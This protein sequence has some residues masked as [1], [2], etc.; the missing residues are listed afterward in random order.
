MSLDTEKIIVA[1]DHANFDECKSF[2][3]NI[4]SSLRFVKVGSILYSAV[5]PEILDFFSKKNVKVFLDLKYH[6]IPNTVANSI[7][8]VLK[9]AP[10]DLLT[11][12]ASG[13]REMIFEAKQAIRE[14]GQKTELVAVTILTSLDH[15]NLQ[16]IGFGFEPNEAVVNLARLAI[17]SGADGIVCSS[18]ELETVRRRIPKKM[19]I[20][21]PG[22]RPA[23]Q[24]KAGDDQKRTAT[25]EYAFDQGASYI[26]VGRPITQAKN[27]A[28]ILNKIVKGTR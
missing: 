17:D 16:E 25:P 22:I 14:S 21:V 6:D 9:H 24:E 4:G 27:P 8:S 10:I 20:V 19:T 15:K 28:E 18:A 26:V 5:G 3:Q 13:G 23:F 11:I 1:L 2:I 7:S 12:H